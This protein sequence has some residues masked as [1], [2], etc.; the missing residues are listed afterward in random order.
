MITI[1]AQLRVISTDA[2]QDIPKSVCLNVAFPG[3]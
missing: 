3:F 2:E 1:D